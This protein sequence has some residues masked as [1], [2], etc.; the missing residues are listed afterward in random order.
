LSKYYF[1]KKA[2]E[3]AIGFIE[4]FVTHTKGELTGQPLKLEKWQSKI[5]GDIFGWKNKETNLRKYRTVFIEVPRK[6]GKSTLCAAIGLYMLF[7]DEERGS[8][9]YSAAGDRSQAGIVFEIAKGM[10]MQNAELSQRSKVYRNSILNESKGNFYQAISSDSKT[11]HGFNANCIIFDELHTQPNRSLF[12]T[13][14]TSTGSR[15]QP[16]TIAITT[17]GYDKQSI[18]Y[19]IYSYAKKIKDGTIKDESFYPVIYESEN[20]DDIT[21]ESTWKKANPNYGISLKKEYMQRESQRAVDVPSYQNTFRRL[22]LNQWTDSYSAWLTS[23][24]WNACHQ[25]FDYSKLENCEAWGG[26]DLASTRDLTAFVLLFNVDGKF[27]FI[28]YIFIPEENAKKRSE[29]DGVDYVTWLKDGHIFATPG[30]VA[31]YNFIRAKINELSKKYRIQSVCYDRWGA[32]QL[33]VDLGNDGCNLDPFGQGFV[34]MSMPTKTLEAEIL[35]KNII[36][37]NN[38]CMNWCMSNVA[39]QEDGAGNIKVAKNRAKEKVDPV[40]AL[41]MALGCYLTT[42]SSDSVYDERDILVL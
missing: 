6:N 33:I 36:H 39:L 40:V 29:R 31:D 18:C 11:K 22:M 15:R 28:P 42:E 13:L 27:V 25:E 8:E 34:S 7:A 3:K 37:N 21:L 5:V 19:E 16:L 24:E 35:A 38:P 41:I 12:D 9:V 2:A 32:S 10:I 20:A 17:A 26:L 1:D 4:T 30:N 14:T 23:S